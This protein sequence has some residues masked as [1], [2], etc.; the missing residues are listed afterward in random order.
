MTLHM[1]FAYMQNSET[2]SIAQIRE[3]AAVLVSHGAVTIAFLSCRRLDSI[4][5]VYVGANSARTCISS[6]I[7]Y[8]AGIL[9]K[10]IHVV[11]H[12]MLF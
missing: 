3:R 2:I 9:Y 8:Y 11:T 5:A 4:P 12:N 6:G 10:P 7:I 1:I